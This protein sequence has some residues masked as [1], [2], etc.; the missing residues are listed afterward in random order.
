MVNALH[1]ITVDIRVRF[2]RDRFTGSE[3]AGFILVTLELVG[4]TSAN[5][6]NVTVTPSEQSPVSAEGNSVMCMI[7]CWVKSVWLTGGVDFNTTPLTVT[8]DSGITMSSVSVPVMA[9]D[10]VEGNQSLTVTMSIPSSVYKGIIAS[11]KYTATMIII[12]STCEYCIMHHCMTVGN[13]DFMCILVA[14]R[15]TSDPISITVLEKATATLSCNAMASGPIRY[16]WRR[17]NG[18]INSDRA[19]GVNTPTLTISPVQ[20]EDEDEYYCVASYG[21]VNDTDHSDESERARLTVF[22][23]QLVFVNDCKTI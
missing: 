9:D 22:G 4:G 6:F 21:V 8:F 20:Q 19:E 18:E 10:I 7:M 2:T 14:A 23:K 5:S 11:D 1:L 16:Q 3:A 17:V 12:D 13:S 15:I